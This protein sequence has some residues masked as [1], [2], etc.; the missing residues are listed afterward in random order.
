MTKP[1]EARYADY[2]PIRWWEWAC[3]WCIYQLIMA[4]HRLFNKGWR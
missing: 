1:G 3:A 2:K 4:P